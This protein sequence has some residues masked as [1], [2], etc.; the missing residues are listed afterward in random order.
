MNHSYVA[1]SFRSLPKEIREAI[2]ETMELTK[3]QE[4]IR[5]PRY[6]LGVRKAANHFYTKM[7][8]V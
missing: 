4:L 1:I 6:G 3:F 7:N 5:R 8:N 2:E